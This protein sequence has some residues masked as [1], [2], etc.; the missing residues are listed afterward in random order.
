MRAAG[1]RRRRVP[2][3]GRTARR[4]APNPHRAFTERSRGAVSLPAS[5]QKVAFAVCAVSA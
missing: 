4:V 3:R 2:P 1:R 5:R